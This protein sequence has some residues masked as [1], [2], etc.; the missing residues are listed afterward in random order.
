MLE[1]SIIQCYREHFAEITGDYADFKK[2]IYEYFQSESKA[3][4]LLNPIVLTE[5]TN[6]I[7]EYDKQ[8]IFE[9]V[10]DLAS[11]MASICMYF[12]GSYE[13]KG[14]FIKQLIRIIELVRVEYLRQRDDKQVENC[15]KIPKETVEQLISLKILQTYYAE[16]ES[17]NQPQMEEAMQTRHILR[18]DDGNNKNLNGI[19]RKLIE[20]QV[21][22]QRPEIHRRYIDVEH[23]RQETN[24]LLIELAF[25]LR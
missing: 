15:I 24:K 5:I 4:I 12:I 18:G 11:L 2:P 7:I 3:A 1:E 8:L 23:N 9:H 16:F 6:L 14:T 19:S 17:Y 22:I 21:Y 20:R 25:K 10:V 13:L